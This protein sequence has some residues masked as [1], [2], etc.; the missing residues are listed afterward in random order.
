MKAKA[1]C[2]SITIQSILAVI[3]GVLV[4]GLAAEE[5]L[6]D[7]VP[8]SYLKYSKPTSHIYRGWVQEVTLYPVAITPP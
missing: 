1:M 3:A 8:Y 4:Y 2:F 7:Y 5:H 6:F